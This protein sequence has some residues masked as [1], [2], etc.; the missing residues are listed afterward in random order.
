MDAEV[1][2]V[3]VASP[4]DVELEREVVDDIAKRLEQDRPP[5]LHKVGSI[6]VLRWERFAYPA[7]GRPER[8]ILDQVG[9]YDILLAILWCRCGTP[10][11]HDEHGH[12]ISSSGTLEEI[13]DALCR[14]RDGRLR[15]EQLL[16][17]QCKRPSYFETDEDFLQAQ[18][19]RNFLARI[20][21]KVLIRS[22]VSVEEFRAL[23]T[24][25]LP[26]VI[27]KLQSDRSPT[28]ATVAQRS[29]FASQDSPLRLPIDPLV[30][31]GYLS[32]VRAL[33]E[34]DQAETTDGRRF[35]VL[36]GPSGSGKSILAKQYFDDTHSES[37]VWITCRSTLEPYGEQLQLANADLIVLD[38]F[39][40][41]RFCRDVLREA[42][43]R[44]DRGARLVVT[45][46]DSASCLRELRHTGRQRQSLVDV[47]GVEQD[48]WQTVLAKLAGGRYPL[49]FDALYYRFRGSVAGL[50]LLRA[51]VQQYDDPKAKLFE[52]R[53]KLEEQ[54]PVA[55][56]SYF[57]LQHAQRKE[58]RYDAA[59]HVAR[60]WW[61]KNFDAGTV[62]WVLSCVPLIGMSA[63]TLS[64]VVGR[65]VDEIT[66][67]L[68]A[69]EN[70]AFIYPLQLG[71]EKVWVPLDYFRNAFESIELVRTEGKLLK[72][73]RE[74]YLR[75]CESSSGVLE[76]LDAVFV[77]AINAFEAGDLTAIEWH[78]ERCMRAL[79]RLREAQAMKES[80]WLPIAHAIAQ[81][82]RS[83]N[84]VIPI[85]QNLTF[86]KGHPDLG[87]LAWRMTEVADLWAASVAAFAAIRHW[88]VSPSL[89]DHAEALRQR[90]Q[91]LLE[92]DHW[93]S[94]SRSSELS[95]M[96]PAVLIGGLGVFGFD[97]QARAELENPQFR[98]RFPRSTFAHAVPIVRAA[99]QGLHAE[100][101]KLISRHWTAVR[102]GPVKQFV[103]EYV[104][105]VC[106]GI[107]APPLESAAWQPAYDFRLAAAQL[108]F[109]PRAVRYLEDKLPLRAS[110]FKDD[111]LAV[112]LFGN[113]E[114]IVEA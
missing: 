78:L 94:A 71:N 51:A 79:R 49:V 37:K 5:D 97:D 84:Q 34:S 41:R 30:R 2:R 19:L 81:R 44:V 40:D 46:T 27:R 47:R 60:I 74:N 15:S 104:S 38:G 1:I 58:F 21:K 29:S 93:A 35:C 61:T 106:P 110:R 7:A 4:G 73:F 70:E 112:N 91:S 113:H 67:E 80:Q 77:R 111:K 87:D 55:D 14:H 89:A 109:S 105:H 52:I 22:Y 90:L 103:A 98:K 72:E 102:D 48:E 33:L 23:L 92:A 16:I 20:G 9:A 82:A 6:Q 56:D 53:Q 24:A 43:R 75:L 8:V 42:L 36:C 95:D 59:A 64:E 13:D 101:E 65:D 96:L 45:T 63:A 86:L 76:R 54:A 10:T 69:L 83:C 66:R 25:H 26:D 11:G 108:A 28:P 88:S 114:W 18:E 99:D 39:E 62:F 31:E 100:V 3:F 50:Q 17:Y 12:Q 57:S 85:A 107:V 68:R 32:R